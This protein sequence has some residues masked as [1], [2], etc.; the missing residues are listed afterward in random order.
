[1]TE[2]SLEVSHGP[3]QVD[4]LQEPGRKLKVCQVAATAEG[5]RWMVEQLRE[6]RDVYG[7]DVLA[8]VGSDKGGLSDNLRANN[9]PYYAEDFSFDALWSFLRLP[10]TILR[11]ARMVRRERV[12]V[13]QSHLFV[14]ML[15]TRFAAWLA[16]VPVRLSMYASPFQLQ[17]PIPFWM[18]R[19]TCWMD[20]T[21]IPTCQ[22]IIDLCRKMGVRDERL[23][24]VH[25]GPDERRFDPQKFEAAKIREEYGWPGDTP[26]IGQVALFYAEQ[27][28]S[29]WIPESVHERGIKGF[30]D[31][32]NAVPFVLEEIP[33]AKF[34][35]VGSAFGEAGQAHLDYIKVLVNRLG[36]K[37]S[38]IFTGYRPDVNEVLRA[39]DVAL[40]VSLVECLGGA[41]ESLLMERPTVATRVGGMV[42]I[43]RDGETGI[44]VE[45]S[46]PRDLARGIL[47]MLRSGEQGKAM[48]QAGRK[49]I[50]E[51]FTLRSTAASL[52]ELFTRLR[53][54]RRGYN[55]LLYPWRAI[56]ASLVYGYIV[57][58]Y[59]LLE[60]LP[61][62]LPF[63]ASRIKY[64]A[65]RN[66][67]RLRNS[68]TSRYYRTYYRTRRVGYRMLLP[69]WRALPENSRLRI[70]HSLGKPD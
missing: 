9:I 8:V 7:C 14:S 60:L 12:D 59:A 26:L 48:G 56:V 36:L 51:R 69:V 22:L 63:Y 13:V 31:I 70:K 10:A 43:V 41:V 4:R 23:A 16:D 52:F 61:I 1:M 19:A 39:L 24:L 45:P 68:F 47:Q 2:P 64:L 5:G 33:N 49:L 27:H 37:D 55:L 35:L 40:Q 44:L 15:V 29:R 54:N 50:L 42:D 20:S 57:A 65:H 46:N 18:D 25:Y 28:K 11:L 62:Y 58:R 34:L 32:V 66:C 3:T 38:V 6:L 21:L 17:A 53:G 67:Y 30:D